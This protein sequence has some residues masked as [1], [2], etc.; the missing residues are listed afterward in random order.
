MFSYEQSNALPRIHIT[1]VLNALCM[2][3]QKL[4]MLESL[5]IFAVCTPCVAVEVMKSLGGVGLWEFG[6]LTFEKWE[7]IGTVVMDLVQG[8]DGDFASIRS[9]IIGISDKVAD[10]LRFWEVIGTW[11]GRRFRC[12]VRVVVRACGAHAV[13]KE[14]FCKGVR[15]GAHEISC[16]VHWTDEF[17]SFRELNFPI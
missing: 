2:A 7:D 6:A 5:S 13:L 15:A 9:M 16:V 14:A 1:P 8:D 11:I 10:P 12:L 4:T 3:L 17:K